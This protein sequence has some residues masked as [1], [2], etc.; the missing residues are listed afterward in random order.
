M[1]LQYYWRLDDDSLLLSNVSYDVFEFMQRHSLQ[2]GYLWRHWDSL[3]CVE[4]LWE[5]T[6]RYI[7]ESGLKSE[8]FSSWKRGYLYY[9]NF[10]ISS[11][12]MWLSDKYKLYIDYIDRL[13]GIFYNRWG[14][15]P[16]HGIAVSMF[17]PKNQTYLFHDIGYRHGSYR[18]EA[19]RK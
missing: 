12:K 6:E 14:D 10:E 4:G 13:G 1:T 7:A 16:L 9:N 2:Y 11:T 15:A 3:T 19:H 8:F 5:A 17:V 18:H